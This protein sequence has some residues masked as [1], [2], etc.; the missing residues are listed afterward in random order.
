MAPPPLGRIYVLHGASRAGKSSISNALQHSVLPTPLFRLS[1]DD[2][3]HFLP[4]AFF[5]IDPEDG[6]PA[7]EGLR[8]L[9]PLASDEVA[10]TRQRLQELNPS[11]LEKYAALQKVLSEL[12]YSARVAEQGIAISCGSAAHASVS[13][14]H[15]AAEHLSRS[16]HNVVL[17]HA[18]L[19]D[20][21]RTDLMKIVEGLPV[22]LV[23]VHAPLSVLEE[24][25]RSGGHR[26]IGQTRGH[27]EIIHK[28]VE[29]DVKLDTSAL[30]PTQCAS[31]ILEAAPPTLTV[32]SDS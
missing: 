11:P 4:Q 23:R 8:W 7:H 30:S 16:G 26:I 15:R 10:A 17:E 9:L 20:S 29:Y 14:M 22:V 28:Q 18:F 31:Q 25:E 27:H 24:R 1:L 3:M 2:F 13:A 32:G 21:W 5:A 19:S 12:G 6:H